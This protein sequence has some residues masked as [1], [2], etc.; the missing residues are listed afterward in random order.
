MF[1]EPGLATYAF[2]IFDIPLHSERYQ[3]VPFTIPNLVYVV[4]PI[5]LYTMLS[6]PRYMRP[7]E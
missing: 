6:L 3:N 4:Q 7:P 2:H 5:F 1:Q